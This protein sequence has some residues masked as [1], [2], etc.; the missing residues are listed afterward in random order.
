ML[1]CLVKTNQQFIIQWIS[2]LKDDPLNVSQWFGKS[3]HFFLGTVLAPAQVGEILNDLQHH[4]EAH[5]IGDTM[6]VKAY[7]TEIDRKHE[8]TFLFQDLTVL[9]K[10]SYNIERDY[11]ENVVQFSPGFMY[12]KGIDFRY[13][14]CNKNFSKAAG[15]N[16]PEEI[17]G[18]TDYDLAWGETEAD[19]FREGDKQVLSGFEKINFEEPQL[20]S[21]GQTKIVLANKVPLRD[22]AGNII[23]ILG[24]YVDI[25]N[26][27]TQEKTLIQAKEQA[28]QADQVKTE[29]I[30][31]MEHDIRTPFSG[32]LGMSDR[33]FAQ[34]TDPDKKNALKTVRESAKQLLCYM[35]DVLDYSRTE[36]GL[37]PVQLKKLNVRHLMDRIVAIESAIASDK[38]LT[39]TAHYDDQVP[40]VIL[41]DCYRVERI[42]I[43]LVSNALKFTKK[44]S[45]VLS[46]KCIKIIDERYALIRFIIEDTGIGIP[47][48][49]MTYIYQEFSRLNQPHASE[50]RGTGLGLRV[51]KQFVSDL[52]GELDAHSIEGKGTTFYV[53]LKTKIPLTNDLIS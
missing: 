4:H 25:S 39:L 9:L 13:L 21:D 11:L 50:Y 2:E 32:L 19:L 44:G 26:R 40:E 41:A 12:L 18:K 27:K 35:D 5:W 7:Q 52:D 10:N 3:I 20:Q 6:Q 24:N 45:V 46:L 22:R 38:Q 37:I 8:Y 36:S 29:F 31:H 51:V 14:M 48:D 28:E 42:L 15:L 33:L 47:S 1:T 34:E 23:G 16:S 53:T 17:I 49:K 30:R 43:N